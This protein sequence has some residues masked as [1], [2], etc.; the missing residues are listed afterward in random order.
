ME[1]NREEQRRQRTDTAKTPVVKAVT[2]AD[3][4]SP[5]VRSL[6]K[7]QTATA[8]KKIKTETAQEEELNEGLKSS[9]P[10]SDPVSVVS[11][12]IP[13]GHAGKKQ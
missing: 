1:N 3:K 7:E 8:K 11:S 4:T 12:A 2:T 6:R 13:T 9:F 10:A 5:A